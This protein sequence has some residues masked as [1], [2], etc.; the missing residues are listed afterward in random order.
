MMSNREMYSGIR[1]NAVVCICVSKIDCE[2]NFYCLSRNLFLG[3]EMASFQFVPWHRYT[4]V[5]I[6]SYR[7]SPYPFPLKVSI[8]VTKLFI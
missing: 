2:D 4:V 6:W 5:Y 7:I 3:D 8:V 1:S